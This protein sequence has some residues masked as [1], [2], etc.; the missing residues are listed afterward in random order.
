MFSAESATTFARLRQRRVCVPL[1]VLAVLVR[2]SMASAIAL[3]DIA[4]LALGLAS[5]SFQAPPDTVP[6][7]LGNTTYDQW[8]D[9]RFRPEQSLWK[10]LGLPFQLQLF[11][12]GYYYKR[13][14]AVDVVDAAGIHPLRFAPMQFDY[15]RNDFASKIPPDLGYAGLRLHAPIK[16]PQYFDEVI[17]FLGASYFRAVGKQQVFGLSARGLA[18]DTALPSGEEFPY[19]REFWVVQPEQTDASVTMFALLDSPSLA[20]AYEFRI[21]P[22]DQTVVQVTA[23]LFARREVQKLGMAPLTS[24]F[25]HGE[26]ASRGFDD[27][28]PEAHDSDGLLLNFAS[29]EWMWRALDNPRSLNVSA[30]LMPSPR[31]FGLIQRDRNFEHYQDLET[32]FDLRPS[33]WVV[34]EGSWGNG[35]AELVEI[36]TKADANDNIRHAVHVWLHA[37]LVRQHHP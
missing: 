16:T 9:I 33:G 13:S 28:R 34:P 24:M 8:R 25:F 6:D 3:D 11:H 26:N 30:F 36:P 17:V 21:T 12:P 29:G 15:G 18:I 4:A 10:N 31:G 7:W 35:H 20:G 1:L 37:L 22:G 27:F 32:R 2:S 23:R 19:F 14:V 5:D